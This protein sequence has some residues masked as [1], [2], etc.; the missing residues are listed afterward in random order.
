MFSGTGHLH[1]QRRARDTLEQELAEATVI[2]QDAQAR[3]DHLDQTQKGTYDVYPVVHFHHALIS[4][5][6]ECGQY[7]SNDTLHRSRPKATC[8]KQLSCVFAFDLAALW[9]CDSPAQP[10]ARGVRPR[11]AGEGKQVRDQN[12]RTD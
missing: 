4:D 5:T 8:T 3:F 9:S 12:N 11:R 6:A 10:K 2:N 7:P 1:H